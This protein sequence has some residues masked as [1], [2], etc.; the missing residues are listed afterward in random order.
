VT[1]GQTVAL[2]DYG[3]GNLRSVENAL[4]EVGGRVVV[5]RDPA[6]VAK[7]DRLRVTLARGEL[8]CNVTGHGATETQSFF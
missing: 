5:T 8:D 7:G 3:A 4:R 6:A 2:I 1:D